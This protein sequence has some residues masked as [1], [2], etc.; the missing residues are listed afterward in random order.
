M[1]DCDNTHG[2]LYVLPSTTLVSKYSHRQCRMCY[3]VATVYLRPRVDEVMLM[4]WVS[5][6]ALALSQH[7][8]S[9]FSHTI[10]VSYKQHSTGNTSHYLHPVILPQDLLLS[11]APTL[12]TLFLL[13]LFSPAT[14]NSAM[15]FL[16]KLKQ[17]NH[18]GDDGSLSNHQAPMGISSS[19][20]G[21]PAAELANRTFHHFY[22]SQ[23]QQFQSTAKSEST[24]GENDHFGY[25]VWP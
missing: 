12:L 17:H 3:Q 11:T 16:Q 18:H 23:F 14:Q 8:T 15:T 7:L 24:L 21:S 2:G 6:S 4:E 10:T 13:L 1:T 25:V 20:I 22:S 9:H 19:S 5:A